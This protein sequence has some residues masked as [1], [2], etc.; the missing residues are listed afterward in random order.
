[1]SAP[2]AIGG[3]PY[4]ALL[5]LHRQLDAAQRDTIA[6]WCRA[7]GVAAL[8]VLPAGDYH[9]AVDLAWLRSAETTRPRWRHRRY[10]ED[11]QAQRGIDA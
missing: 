4:P 8:E 1:M 2:V 7:H 5:E 11:R 9:R 10:L 3:V 6:R